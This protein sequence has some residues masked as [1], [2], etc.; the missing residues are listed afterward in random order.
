VQTNRQAPDDINTGG[1]FDG[2]VFLF[3]Y[4]VGVEVMNSGNGAGSGEQVSEGGGATGG[5]A[6]AP[7]IDPRLLALDLLQK[8]PLPRPVFCSVGAAPSTPLFRLCSLLD[9]LGSHA[10]ASA[11]PQPVSGLPPSPLNLAALN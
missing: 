3:D 11:G 8:R 2:W 5:P 7:P 10:P 9:G 6:M 1:D 4:G